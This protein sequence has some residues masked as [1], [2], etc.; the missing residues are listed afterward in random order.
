[1]VRMR[2]ERIDALLVEKGIV[3]SR[4]QA[5][6][7]IRAGWV[8]VDGERADKPGRRYREEAEITLRQKPRYVGR[9]GDKLKGALRDFKINVKDKLVLDVG[10]ST[11]GFTDCLLQEGARSVICLDVGKG[12]LDWKLRRDPRVRVMEGFN[13]RYLSAVDLPGPV[14]LITVDVSFISLTKVLPALNRVLRKKGGILA[15][16][17]PQ[18][19]AARSEVKR[20][21]VVRESSVHDKVIEKIKRALAELEMKTAG[22]SPSDLEGPAGNR[23]FFILAWK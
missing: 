13:A 22:V 17:K 12:Q 10:S 1:M 8:F 15:L 20:G 5:Q 9:G 3:P 4:Q 6:R 16:I 19:E 14:D 11:G 7:A 21:G 18:F 2:R 23:E